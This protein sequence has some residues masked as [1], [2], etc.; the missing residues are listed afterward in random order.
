MSTI[1]DPGIV[2]KANTVA[3][4][5]SRIQRYKE[6]TEDLLK[7]YFKSLYAAP[8]IVY[9]ALAI[10]GLESGWNLWH[11]KSFSHGAD[12]VLSGYD[13]SHKSPVPVETSS[14]IRAYWYSPVIQN[15]VKT[16]GFDVNI[17]TAL[18]QG[19]VAH[20]LSACMGCYHVRGT[21]TNESFKPY[22]KV[23]GDLGLEVNPGESITA[24]FPQNETGERR[25]IAAGLIILDE[26]YKIAKK[27]FKSESDAIRAAVGYYVGKAGAKDINGYSAED[28][29]KGV[30]TR[31]NVQTVLASIGVTQ[32]G[33]VAVAADDI[34]N[35]PR[36]NS[37]SGDSKSN[38]TTSTTVAM[39][40]SKSPGCA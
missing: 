33:Y 36:S 25:S 37:G 19:R 11:K 21:K 10:F 13:S 4:D 9:V 28:R 16:K 6:I 15:L 14:L 29:I 3:K 40:A 26:K 20:G 2:K 35:N 31:S 39:K 30:Y 12:T 32:S 7:Q 5:Y 18:H 24:L 17:M 38:T 23:V 22:S 1:S 27:Q 34:S 8:D